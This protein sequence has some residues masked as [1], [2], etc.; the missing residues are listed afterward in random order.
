MQR[1][2]Y[3]CVGCV[4]LPSFLLLSSWNWVMANAHRAGGDHLRRR[5]AKRGGSITYAELRRKVCSLT[6]TFGVKLSRKATLGIYLPT[7]LH[8]AA[9]A[10]LACTRATARLE[11]WPLRTCSSS[12]TCVSPSSSLPSYPLLFVCVFGSMLTLRRAPADQQA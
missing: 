11:S 2:S 7:T 8:A 3:N 6:S 4:P 5:R 10:F 9:A 12:S 1:V